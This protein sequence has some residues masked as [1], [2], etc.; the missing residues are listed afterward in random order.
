MFSNLIYKDLRRGSN[1]FPL[2][3]SQTLLSII[4]LFVFES[5]LLAT[6]SLHLRI[7][8]GLPLISSENIYII[9]DH[10]AIAGGGGKIIYFD[11]KKWSDF[12]P[13]LP[14]K[15]II[16]RIK[17]YSTKNI[18]VFYEKHEDY[19]HQ[20]CYHFD[21][22]KWKRIL[23]PQPFYF[24]TVSFI[25]SMCFFAGGGW[26]SMIFFDGKQAHN[27][28]V[29][30]NVH[31]KDIAPF[32]K[33][34]AYVLVKINDIPKVVN[35]LFEY[36]E[37][38]WDTLFT[39]SID[40][41]NLRFN[42]ADSGYVFSGNKDC[43]FYSKG[44][45]RLIKVANLRE[46]KLKFNRLRYEKNYIWDADTIWQAI[47][48]RIMPIY[49]FPH[50]AF[51]HPFAQHQF[52][53]SSSS[54]G[55]LYYLGDKNI[56]Q[57]LDVTHLIFRVSTMS[58]YTGGAIGVAAYKDRE[59]YLNLY[60]TKDEELNDFFV[61][62][63]KAMPN[64]I[65]DRNLKENI[66]SAKPTQLWDSGV[67]FADMDNDGDADAIMTFLRGE[68]YLFENIGHDRFKNVTN[69]YDFHLAGR[70]SNVIWCDLNNDG[71]LDF[72]SGD[73]LGAL[74]IQINNGFGIFKDVRSETSLPDSLMGYNPALADVDNDGDL[75]LF[76]YGINNPIHY[77]ENTGI[78]MQTG[79]PQFVQ[80]D[81]KSP[82]LTSHFDFFTHAMRFADYDNDGDL[83][84]F[85]ANRVSPTKLFENEGNGRF[86][87]VSNEKGFN[88]RLMAYGANWGDLNLDGYQDIFVTTMGKN[89]VFW[90]QQGQT[91]KMDSLVLPRNNL[92]Y[93]IG[94][95]LTDIDDD[96]D[97]DIVV[98]NYKFG[99]SIIYE[100]VQKSKNYIKIALQGTRSN[101]NGLGSKVYLY[102]TG[103]IGQRA[104]LIGYR[105]LTTNTGYAS[106]K[107][108][109]VHFG[110][111]AGKKFD[112]LVQFP[113]GI[114]RKWVGLVGSHSFLLNESNGKSSSIGI[115]LHTIAA[116]VFN[117][118]ERK[119][120]IK[121][122]YFF[123]LLIAFNYLIYKTTFWSY[124]NYFFFNL[125]MLFAVSY[126][127]F[128][129]QE[130]DRLYLDFLGYVAPLGVGTA[131]YV[132]LNKSQKLRFSEEDQWKLFDLIRQLNH[133]HSGVKQ[134]DHLIFFLN[135]VQK[136]RELQDDLIREFNYFKK[137]SLTFIDGI[138]NLVARWDFKLAR[139]SKIA[140]LKKYF[141]KLTFN[142]K[143]VWKEHKLEDIHLH[144][145]QLK[146]GLRLI[147]QSTYGLYSCDLF[148]VITEVIGQFRDFSNYSIVNPKNIASLQV[149]I[150]KQTLVQ[151]LENLFQN[152]LEAMQKR[153]EKILLIEIQTDEAGNICLLITNWGE[154]IARENRN[155]IFNEYFSTKRSS[156]LGLFHVK[157]LLEKYNGKITL[158]NSSKET[159]TTFEIKLR[160]Y[161]N[162]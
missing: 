131:L 39:T 1:Q 21:G 156:G 16:S 32:S 62:E 9:N 90:N 24:K 49:P 93:S 36:K 77:F 57:P 25:D 54:D 40:L 138:L 28:R 29:P 42:E 27:I 104:H 123:I 142:A 73:K 22:V 114:N 94:S 118:R 147:K 81:D 84:L 79:L 133:T 30:L 140:G 74:S 92:S 63:K 155:K 69:E 53:L 34:R 37:G 135:N 4:V 139:E 96:G 129:L 112:I 106:S 134:I 52:F 46:K 150:L 108:P 3:N 65:L 125:L 35:C 151:I 159:G 51:I 47:S 121:I 60:F 100:N 33:H 144:L 10:Q 82:Q 117:P 122:I 158:L 113:S 75:D 20:D 162:E 85:L 5:N 80:E 128:F 70:I 38:K 160:K 157:N 17:A 61:L 89:Y 98:A 115:L 72:V 132:L 141:L 86:I 127:F 101:R 7:F 107:L 149:F 18:W 48:G 102:D 136:N 153:A 161:P 91:F 109:E 154:E 143:S 105:E 12:N 148:S 111:K 88:R 6:D 146:E 59:G 19:Y 11:G 23:L 87:D 124:S 126:L 44:R 120:F 50:P 41:R 45:L 95:I 99:H 13:P 43:Y 68:S 15:I 2:S 83:D 110:Y 103:Y 67:F 66:S 64:E 56:G 116:L 55:R 71:F 14:E 130:S 78:D 97:L 31:I 58:K 119:Q 152:A 76:L 137:N 145:R 8:P 26:G